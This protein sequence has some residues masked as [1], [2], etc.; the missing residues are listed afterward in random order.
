MWPQPGHT[1][2]LG[3]FKTSVLSGH[4]FM[5]R[6]FKGAEIKSQH[7]LLEHPE[8][9]KAIQTQ[10]PLENESKAFSELFFIQQE[11]RSLP[12]SPMK[13][14]R[15]ASPCAHSLWQMHLCP[16]PFRDV[17]VSWGLGDLLSPPTCFPLVPEA[18]SRSK[19]MCLR[20]AGP[21]WWTQRTRGR[22]NGV[23]RP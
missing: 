15:P 22:E 17:R 19:W 9:I 3:A 7:V 23:T 18:S 12:P 4:H 16:R 14:I 6:Q 5:R 21:A 2:R 10:K 20:G 13:G 11:N 8:F 1:Y